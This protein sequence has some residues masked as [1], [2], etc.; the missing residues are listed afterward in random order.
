MLNGQYV[1]DLQ[2]GILLSLSAFLPEL[3]LCGGIV[4]ILILRM[5]V[6]PSRLHLGFVA[7]GF[8]LAALG[9]AWV[10]WQSDL[11]LSGDPQPLSTFGGMI[12]FD[13]L[14]AF[15]RIFLLGVSALILVLCLLTG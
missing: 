15:V 7:L 11:T 4:L 6:R 1:S 12:V 13:R 14:T 2:S 10:Q 8:T 5:L 9:M 3:V